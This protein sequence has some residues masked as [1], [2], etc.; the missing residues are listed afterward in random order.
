MTNFSSGA[1]M[2]YGEVYLGLNSLKRV[3][4]IVTGKLRTGN[5]EI[6]W[7]HVH[8]LTNGLKPYS[9]YSAVKL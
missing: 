7:Y 4:F 1:L 6:V 5:S 8:S 9:T 2:I 3:P